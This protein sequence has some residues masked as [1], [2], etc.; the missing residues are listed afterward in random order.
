[1]EIKTIIAVVG[2]GIGCGAAG[3]FIGKHVT[4]K[5]D[6]ETIDFLLDENN[7][8]YEIIEGSGA[9][10]EDVK[11]YIPES[12][13]DAKRFEE[14]E[15]KKAYLDAKEAI[16]RNE[17]LKAAY[18][19]PEEDEA[20]EDLI[21]NGDG[22]TSPVD[23]AVKLPPYLIT[24]D[25]YED[26]QFDLFSKNELTYFEDGTL[27]DDGDSIVDD[28]DYM[29]G[30]D[31]LAQFDSGKFKVIYIR[32]ENLSADYEITYKNFTYAEWM[33]MPEDE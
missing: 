1:M 8:L 28:V 2:V 18:L 32:N 23:L 9:T 27:I 29:V 12:D 16:K 33:G 14:A 22:T 21:D 10:D 5:K 30:L 11:N 24:Q 6:Q 31:N 15:D 17:E 7:K 20:E 25:E 13:E 4:S 26:Q 19:H 3:Y